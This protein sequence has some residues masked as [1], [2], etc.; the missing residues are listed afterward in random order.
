MLVVTSQS[1]INLSPLFVVLLILT[2]FNKGHAQSTNDAIALVNGAAI[3]LQ[4]VDQTV[5]AQ[6]YPLQQQIYAI[7]KSALENLI[8]SRLLEAEARK[9]GISV[10]G[11]RKQFT[12]G[13]ISINS[14]QVEESFTKNASY[15]ASMSPDEAKE[16]LRLDLENKARMKQY[17]QSLEELRSTASISIALE[18]PVLLAID[19]SDSPWRGSANPLVTIVEFSDFECPY[20]RAVQP[21]LKQIL[22]RYGESV[23]LVF[24]HLPLEGHANSLPAAQAAYCAGEQDKFWPFHDALFDSHD[25]SREAIIRLASKL[26]LDESQFQ[27]CLNSERGKAAILKDLQ[28]AQQFR[29]DATPGFVINGKVHSGA[30]GLAAFQELIERELDQRTRQNT[31]SVN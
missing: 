31:S 17:R 10:E 9:R 5:A 11:L 14:A 13:D 26:L 27:S 16:R 20:C 29:I 18:Q 30:I 24:K 12:G 4:Q 2:V 15:F 8:V 28:V 19:V 1:R 23:K 22:S 25:L 3:T 7:R 21:S 6:I